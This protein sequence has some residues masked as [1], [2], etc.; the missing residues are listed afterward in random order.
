MSGVKENDMSNGEVLAAMNKNS[1]PKI[2][3]PTNF[4]QVFQLLKWFFYTLL[5][6]KG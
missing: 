2:Q 6:F 1:S 3:N 5:V 4:P